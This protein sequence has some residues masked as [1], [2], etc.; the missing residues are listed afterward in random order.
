MNN[1]DKKKSK[2]FKILVA[3]TALFTGL[4]LIGIVRFSWLLI[5]LPLWGGIA[6]KYIKYL[7]ANIKKTTSSDKIEK[8]KKHNEQSLTN[9]KKLQKE[10]T[11]TAAKNIKKVEKAEITENLEISPTP[12]INVK[13]NTIKN[14]EN[15]KVNNTKENSKTNKN[16]FKIEL[17]N[18][19]FPTSNNPNSLIKTVDVDLI[20]AVD[21]LI[22]ATN[23]RLSKKDFLEILLQTKTEMQVPSNK[24]T[25]WQLN[26]KNVKALTSQKETQILNNRD[27]Q[28]IEAVNDL[29]IFS[30][31]TLT[32][33]NIID[34]LN[35]ISANKQKIYEK[36][37]TRTRKL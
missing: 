30:N 11:K 27:I 19:S 36:G 22:K 29:V 24:N 8:E 2:A 10:N 34:E 13:E 9:N 7:K 25:K 31:N 37:Q 6:G 14:D 4:K 20:K 33:Q 21:N 15:N 28:I 18:M 16:N 5:L 3:L 26:F 32:K 12:K 35:N 1:K 23:N 17:K